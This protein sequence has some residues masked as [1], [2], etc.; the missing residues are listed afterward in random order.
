MKSQTYKISI[1]NRC[2]EKWDGMTPNEKGRF[3]QACAKTVVDFSTWA[4][5]DILK[6]LQ[7]SKGE[8]CGRMSIT[9]LSRPYKQK[10]FFEKYIFS[11][12]VKAA[13]FLIVLL[14]LKKMEAQTGRHDHMRTGKPKVHFALPQISKGEVEIKK[15]DEAVKDSPVNEPVLETPGI[16][17]GAMRVETIKDLMPLTGDTVITPIIDSPEYEMVKNADGVL[18]KVRKT[19]SFEVILQPYPFTEILG[20]PIMYEAWQFDTAWLNGKSVISTGFVQAEPLPQKDTSPAL[21]VN[22]V[23]INFNLPESSQPDKKPVEKDAEE[24]KS[25][26][27]NSS[28]TKPKKFRF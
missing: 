10:T 13:A 17:E 19:S 9:Q 20:G 1:P 27:L 5:E 8:T 21:P 16:I 6:Y 25:G 26:V 12:M 24:K 11:R 15:S 7:K 23:H 3:C 28:E 22:P 2:H 4:D 18:V 14:K